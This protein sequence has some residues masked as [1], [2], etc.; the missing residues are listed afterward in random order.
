[1][2]VTA[3]CLLLIAAAG[4]L[5]PR[6]GAKE[7]I[8]AIP[9]EEQTTIGV[10][11]LARVS[12]PATYHYSVEAA[13]DSLV[14]VRRSKGAVIYRAAKPGFET[15]LLS[16]KVPNGHCISCATIHYFVRVV[17]GKAE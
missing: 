7:R 4:L 11:Q 9:P 2:R 13:G 17:S 5:W 10:G 15:I 3:L 12:I 1:M 14:E 8:Q 16:P 6:A